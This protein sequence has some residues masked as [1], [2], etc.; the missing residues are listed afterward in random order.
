ML[1]TIKQ[2]DT[3]W[4]LSVTVLPVPAVLVVLQRAVEAQRRAQADEPQVARKRRAHGSP[5]GAQLDRLSSAASSL[6]SAS[7]CSYLQ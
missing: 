4:F 7:E 2:I 5:E 3:D 6:S 1:E